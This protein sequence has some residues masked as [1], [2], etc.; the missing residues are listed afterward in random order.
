MNITETTTLKEILN[1][2]PD[3]IA[4]FLKHGVDIPSE[5]DES[6][7]DCELTICEGMCHIEN[8]DALILDLQALFDEPQQTSA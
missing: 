5:C 7:H 1:A 2:R 3:A 6:V 4:V 8:L